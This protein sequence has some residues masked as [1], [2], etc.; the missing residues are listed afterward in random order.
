MDFSTITDP[1][2]RR[3]FEGAYAAWEANHSE[4]VVE[5][6]AKVIYDLTANEITRA[7]ELVKQYVKKDTRGDHRKWQVERAFAR[8]HTEVNKKLTL[9]QFGHI[10][11]KKNIV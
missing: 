8:W 4:N 2:L 11:R 9:A 6:E 3:A 1:Q 10:T 5:P 7:K